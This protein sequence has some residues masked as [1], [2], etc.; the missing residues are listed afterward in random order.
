MRVFHL[1]HHV[2]EAPPACAL[3]HERGTWAGGTL[4]WGDWDSPST[5]LDLTAAER[6]AL[7]SKHKTCQPNYERAALVNRLLR[8]GKKPYEIVLQLRHDHGRT[9]IML[10]CAALSRGKSAENLK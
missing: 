2:T 7:R 8:E 9:S 4:C 1:H 5:P 3:L 6:E 10:D